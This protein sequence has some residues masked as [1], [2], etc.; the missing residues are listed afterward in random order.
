VADT[1]SGPATGTAVS[2]PLGT[3]SVPPPQPPVAKGPKLL[4]VDAAPKDP[5]FLAF[6]DALLA[7]VRKHDTK[8]LLSAL[9]PKIRTSFGD[10]GGIDAFRRQ[11]KPDA[12]DSKI[13]NVLEDVLSHGGS[14][15]KDGAGT[16]FWAPY[17]YSAYPDDQD[18]FE[19]FAVIGSNVAMRERPDHDAPVVATLDHDIVRVVPSKEPAGKPAW[20][21]FS[22]ADGRKG[23]IA[24][25]DVRSPIGYR[26]GFSKDKKGTWR[27]NA[28][29]SGD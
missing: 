18:A 27:M 28:L 23:W 25:D 26:A 29:V 14:F 8:A 19:T 16:T 6:R 9:D 12:T 20:R 5:S 22:T 10:G 17:W 21:Q 2:Q 11:W 3:T 4:P 13:W 15:G 1:A 24:P 7:S